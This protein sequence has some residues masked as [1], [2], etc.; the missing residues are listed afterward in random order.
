VYL[1]LEKSPLAV[2]L[3]FVLNPILLD[4]VLEELSKALDLIFF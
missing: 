1:I 2:G 4:H 3:E